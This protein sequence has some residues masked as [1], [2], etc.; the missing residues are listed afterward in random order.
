MS[1][2]AGNLRAP[3]GRP[4]L[5]TIS[6]ATGLSLSTVSLSL[7]GGETLKAET[8][9]KVLDAAKRL[10]YVPDRAGVRLR[11]GKTNVLALVLDGTANSIEFTRYLIEGIG[12]QIKNTRYHLNVTPD[13]DSEGSVSAVDYLLQNRLA[14][15]IILTHTQPRDPRVQLLMD[16]GVPFVTH[17]RTEF[18]SP[19]PYHDFDSEAFVTT[20]VERLVSRG[21]KNLMLFSPIEPTMNHH[22]IVRTFRKEASRHDVAD[23]VS[24]SIRYETPAAEVRRIGYAMATSNDLPDGIICDNELLALHLLSGLRD[25]GAR[26]GVDVLVVAKQA[27][28]LLPT[29][30]PDIDTVGEDIT[31]AGVELVRILLDRIDGGAVENLQTLGPPQAHWVD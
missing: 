9:Q 21:S 18:Y 31:N 3:G 1:D 4:T 19:H 5:K 16:S 20:A 13:F 12:R 2:E 6:E 17:G 26:P 22:L 15:G 23:T 27:S 14:D 7:R 8:R 10:G 28:D 11:T 29:I 25:G 24:D 30:F